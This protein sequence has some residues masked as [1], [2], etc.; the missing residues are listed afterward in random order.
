M[1]RADYQILPS[2]GGF[3]VALA[4]LPESECAALTIHLP[5]G[6]RDD[7]PGLAGLAHFVEHM[8]FKGTARRDARRISLETEDAGA[9]LNACTGEDAT[10]YE[11]RG[12]AATLPLLVDVL[13]D[14]VWHSNFPA[15]EVELEREVIGEEIV[16][17]RENPS[18]HIGDL[19]SAAIWA[20]HP[21]GEPITGSEATLAAIDRAAL[22]DHAARQH[23]REDLVVAVAGPYR[24]AEVMRLLEPVLPA[25][26]AAAASPRFAEPTASRPPRVEERDT[27]QLQLAL[28][29]ATFGRHDPRRHALRLLAT[30]LGEGASSRLFQKLR[31]ERGLCYHVSCDA[32]LFAETG[33]LEIHAGLD[34]DSREE[35]LECIETELRGLAEH[36]P[37]ADELARA[38][39]LIASH[40]RAS[41]ES[42]G[43]HAH[44][45]GECLAHYDTILRPAEAL[46]RLEAVD[47]AAVRELAAELFDPRHRAAAEIRPPADALSGS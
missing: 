18:D 20:P 42:T 41:M 32:T 21:L 19:L 10:V 1:T 15:A 40:T 16:M 34:P 25:P 39:R 5:A 8:A 31:E 44:W 35:A 43:S 22:C 36:G 6:S 9:T 12:D 17:Y 37:G 28:A 27:R 26:R 29:Y 2:S 47:A 14:M 3:R 38:R 23:P 13:A 24:A 45:A 33:A 11:A 30:V 46:A 7:P 4:E